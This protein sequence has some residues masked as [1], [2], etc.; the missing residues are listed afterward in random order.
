[1]NNKEI[2][3]QLAALSQQVKEISRQLNKLYETSKD[4]Q[5]EQIDE[6]F[7]RAESFQ[8]YLDFISQ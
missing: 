2:K 3:E 6:A 5:R 4:E 8:A 7:F 1:M